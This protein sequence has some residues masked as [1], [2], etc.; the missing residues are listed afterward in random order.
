MPCISPERLRAV[1]VD[2]ELLFTPEEFNHMK[3]CPYCFYRWEK[4]IR[5]SERRL[6]EKG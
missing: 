4:Y 5:E 6:E 3:T 1:A 2:D